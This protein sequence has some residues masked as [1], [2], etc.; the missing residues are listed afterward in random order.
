MTNN[1]LV[2]SGEKSRYIAYE[3]IYEYDTSNYYTTE[4]VSQSFDGE[5]QITSAIDY[6]VRED[7]PQVYLL[8]GHGEQELSET[9]T[10][11]LARSN[12]ETVSD[13]S[14]LNVDAVPEDCDALIINAP[15]SD[16]SEEELELLRDYVAAAA[17][18]WCSPARRRK[19]PCPTC[20]RCCLT[21]ALPP[22]RALWWTPTVTHYAFT[23][24]Y[25]LMP[26]IESSEITDPWPTAATM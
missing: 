12:Y 13:F 23:A 6:V 11:E 16:I 15:T 25:V 24:P 4:S 22:P 14:L 8:S 10:D 20:T 17:S 26:D 5:G 9:F 1:S 19:R 2:E 7:L 21:T 18:C 3:D